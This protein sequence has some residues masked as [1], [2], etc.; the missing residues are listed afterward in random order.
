M[1]GSSVVTLLSI[2]ALV[3]VFVLPQG[4]IE[5]GNIYL[6]DSEAADL[7]ARRNIWDRLWVVYSVVA[8]VLTSALCVLVVGDATG[9]KGLK[10]LIAAVSVL[11]HITTMFSFSLIHEM[12]VNAIADTASNKYDVKTRVGPA[13]WI[14]IALPFLSYFKHVAL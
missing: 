4:K 10:I 7:Y 9:R 12:E 2:A 6:Y 11:L 3:L 5:N 13:V 1:L 8:S 14:Q